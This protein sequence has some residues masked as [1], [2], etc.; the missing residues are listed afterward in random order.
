[1]GMS[2]LPVIISCSRQHVLEGEFSF[3]FETDMGRALF[4]HIN[5]MTCKETLLH[6]EF[7]MYKV[8]L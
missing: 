3:S 8:M 1:M 7:R 2:S 6:R 5:E 4:V